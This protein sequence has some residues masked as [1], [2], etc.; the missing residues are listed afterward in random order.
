MIGKL[1]AFALPLN[2]QMAAYCTFHES[3]CRTLENHVIVK[4]QL[5]RHQ[6]N[7]VQLSRFLKTT[8]V[9]QR[10]F[11]D[12]CNRS[13][14]MQPSPEYTTKVSDTAVVYLLLKKLLGSLSKRVTLRNRLHFENE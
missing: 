12:Q 14:D 6:K 8:V 1:D 11:A 4:W 10:C 3:R 5:R 7:N 2:P 13:E 9:Q